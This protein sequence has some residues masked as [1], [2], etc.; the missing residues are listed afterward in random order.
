M[1][2]VVQQEGENDK[3]EEEY[4]ESSHTSNPQQKYPFS[5]AKEIVGRLVGMYVCVYVC[6]YVCACV[7]ISM[8]A[9]ALL[10]GTKYEKTKNPKEKRRTY[11]RV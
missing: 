3:G 1:L 5:M 2:K 10:Y 4:F 11:Q 8:L 7:C 9:Y 6:V